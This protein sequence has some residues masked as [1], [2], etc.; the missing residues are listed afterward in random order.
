[1]LLSQMAQSWVRLQRAQEAEAG[2][3]DAHDVLEAIGNDYK[4]YQAVT[5]LVADTATA[6][7]FSTISGSIFHDVN[8]DGA[9]QSPDQPI[10]GFGLFLDLNNNGRRDTGEPALVTNSA[11]IYTFYTIPAGTYH[12][13]L[14]PPNAWRQRP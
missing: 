10:G 2:Y 4:T 9:L 5:R 1:M 3:F 11:G 7:S 8:G 13:R 6:N 12:V 14:L